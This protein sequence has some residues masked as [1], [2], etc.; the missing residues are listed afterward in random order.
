M[1]AAISANYLSADSVTQPSTDQPSPS[2]RS[3]DLGEPDKH[4]EPTQADGVAESILKGV[5]P[6]LIERVK[7]Q[8]AQSETSEPPAEK[9]GAG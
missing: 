8:L 4:V 2:A 7:S 3:H 1:T 5:D 6:E 9:A